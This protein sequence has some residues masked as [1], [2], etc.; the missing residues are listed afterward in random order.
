MDPAGEGSRVAID[1]HG[2][3]GNPLFRFVSAVILG[4]SR[5]LE[6]WLGDLERSPPSLT[7][8]PGGPSA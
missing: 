6:A 5:T 1:E 8:G 3:V 2:H 4:H 7:A